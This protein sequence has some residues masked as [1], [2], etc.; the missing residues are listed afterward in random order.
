MVLS[1]SD[2][3][4]GSK[5]QGEL[6]PGHVFDEKVNCVLSLLYQNLNLLTILQ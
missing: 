3:E 6:Q 1:I 5:L 2:L 4:S